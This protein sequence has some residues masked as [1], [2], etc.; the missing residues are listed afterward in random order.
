MN[1]N[2]THTTSKMIAFCGVITAFGT[3]LMLTGGLIP[4]LTYCSPLAAGLLLLPVLFEFGTAPALLVWLATALVTLAIGADK[5]AAF[6]Y[7]FLGWYP[8]AKPYLDRIRKKPLRIV[9]KLLLFSVLVAAMYWLLLAVFRLG[10]V[11]ADFGEFSTTLLIVFCALLA[12]VMLI[13]DVLLARMAVVYVR[14]LR[15]KI[16]G[17]L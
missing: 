11:V 8:V 3:L 6:F 5:E 17:L 13:Y 1:R 4:V 14:K 12:A 7:I 10:T 2:S 15:P 16:K 9:V